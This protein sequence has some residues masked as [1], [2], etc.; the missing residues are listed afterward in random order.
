MSIF[1]TQQPPQAQPFG[2]QDQMTSAATQAVPLAYLAGTRIIAATWFAPIYNMRV[3]P[4]PNAGGGGKGGKGGG[5]ATN[6]YYGTLAGAFCRGLVT[7]LVA[8]LLNGSE[9]WPGGTPWA[10]GMNIVA[11]VLYVFDAQ[12]WKC[13]SNHVS[14]ADNAPGSGLEGWMEYSFNRGTADH[15][16]FSI[17]DSSGT[18]YGVITLY[19]G[20]PTQTVDA[21]LA[22]TGNDKGDQHPNYANVCYCVA[23][24]FLLGQDVQSGPNL[25]L[26]LRRPP[27]QTVITGTPA[28]VTDGQ[29]NLAAAAVEILTDPVCIGQSDAVIDDTTFGAA[30][31]W[32][33]ANESLCGASLL[34][35][36]ST[37]LREVFQNITEMIDGWSRFNPATGC[38]E[39][40]VF[41]HG[42]VP[43]TYATLTDDDLTE[44]PD[45]AGTA[46]EQFNSR[47]R[48]SF[49]SRQLA[50]QT[51]SDKYDDARIFNVIGQ[52][53]ELQVRRPYLCRPD[54]A[55][56]LAGETLRVAGMPPATG[57]LKVRR[58]IGRTI[59]A[60]SY[61][62][63]DVTITEGA[64]TT[65]QFFRVTSRQ[66][67]PTGPITLNVLAENTLAAVPWNNNA[68]TI[69]AV[70]QAVPPVAN[71]R[72]LEVPTVLSNARGA[73]LPLVQRPSEIIV[74]CTL[75]FDT[76]RVLGV[77]I[78]SLVANS[79]GLLGVITFSGA[80][81]FSVGD[82]LD[83]AGATNAAFNV[84]LA[85]VTAVSGNTVTYALSAPVSA[86]LAASGTITVADY[87]GTFSSLGS[88]N[89]FAALATLY[90][91]VAATDGTITV[92]VDTTQADAGYF[93]NSY[94]ANDATNDTLLA[95]IVSKVAAGG[96]AGQV[97]ESNGY[98][99]MEICSVSTITLVTA[100]RYTLTVLRGRQQTTA[101]AFATAHTEVWVVPRELIATFTDATFDQIRANR[102][103]GL[104][105]ASAQFRLT[106]YTFV[107]SLALAG[108]GTAQFRF[109]LKSASYPYLLLTTPANFAPAYTG[110]ATWPL[111]VQVAGTWNDPDGNL[112]EMMVT[113][114]K[115]TDAAPRS[116][117]DTTFAP[118]FSR[119]LQSYVQVEG[120][121]TYTVAISARDSTNLTTT[122]NLVM[123][124]TGTGTIQC[125][126][127]QFTDVD[128]VPIVNAMLWL[129]SPL[130]PGITNSLTGKTTKAAVSPITTGLPDN[131]FTYENYNG[132]SNY[133]RIIVTG[134]NSGN[135]T[136]AWGVVPTQNIPFDRLGIFCSTPGSTINFVTTGL[137]QSGTSLSRNN[138]NL[139]YAAGALQPTNAL[140]TGESFVVYA[141]ATAP[142]YAPSALV[143]LYIAQAQ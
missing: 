9:V 119:A 138:Q 36:T 135:Y 126:L 139:V 39:L 89:G 59:R 109:P 142:G 124:V 40:G 101:Q 43:A 33:D 93:T 99:L 92:T 104:T 131:S 75:Y 55:V 27:Q 50:Y 37:T 117:S 88:F 106:P 54:Q 5:G 103:A 4:A 108:A 46:W 48:V 34:I 132:H 90:S 71:Y 15:S 41:P 98:Q 111:T 76:A 11:G 53:S 24:N 128:G 20:T 82:Y 105:P 95:F 19:W 123:T 12:T 64:S 134:Y 3:A 80:P 57:K 30:A 8:I 38:I 74:G 118:C 49:P 10:V 32:L 72:F 52:V 84:S 81:G 69:T 66:I 25:Q 85:V 7:D 116:I 17:T 22:S 58:E 65:S 79:A 6:V 61:V 102:L 23:R 60:G 113:M 21:A 136:W 14:T 28:G 140:T 68:P 133:G 115:S 86:N 97:A 18:Y 78:T 13:T 42:V 70:S 120:P 51:T 96:D 67:P 2:L 122:R 107:S 94:S 114:Q 44:P 127:P 143:A 31:T 63:A 26:V 125:A 47:C 110:G 62:L 16:D 121:G 77:S 112:V 137:V 100:G 87:T 29:V 45:F 83:V 56:A 1:S 129:G 73:V 141:W 91:A 130:D 35:D